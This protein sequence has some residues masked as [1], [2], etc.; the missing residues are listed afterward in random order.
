MRS[1]EDLGGDGLSR[2]RFGVE[3]LRV[4]A[5]L[6][7]GQDA[8]YCLRRP[9]TRVV[10]PSGLA[11]ENGVAGRQECVVIHANTLSG[12]S[13]DLVEVV[14]SSEGHRNHNRPFRTLSGVENSVSRERA[15]EGKILKI[16]GIE[17]R[18]Y[19]MV[20]QDNSDDFGIEQE[21]IRELLDDQ[22]GDR[23]LAGAE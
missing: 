20:A 11:A 13:D 7:L 2:L 8:V 22:V 12:V 3:V 5:G 23:G 14:G 19:E 21:R 6:Q 17:R 10:R 15:P 18:G 9:V 4:A 16:A 1:S